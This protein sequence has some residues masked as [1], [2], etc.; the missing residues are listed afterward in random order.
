MRPVPQSKHVLAGTIFLV[1]ATVSSYLAFEDTR[2]SDEQIYFATA[3]AKRHDPDLY[4]V[5][6]VYGDVHGVVNGRGQLW[7]VQTP[8]FLGMMDMVLVPEGYRHL[9]LPFRLM[10]GVVV[11]VFLVG[12][13]ALLWRQ[14]RSSSIA[15][16]GAVLAATITETFG[17]WFWG[18]GAL[19]SITPQGLVIALSPLLLLSYVRNAERGRVALT[20]GA[21]GLCANLHLISAANLALILF[22]VYL[23]QRRFSLRSLGKSLLG[24]G[25]FAIGAFPYLAYFFALR[26]SLAADA[27]ATA[28]TSSVAVI[29]ALRISDMAVLYPELLGPLLQWGIYAVILAVPPALVLWR[30]ERFRTRDAGVWLW[31]VAVSLL[32]GLVL[33]GVSQALGSL[34]GSAPPIIDFIQAVSWSMLALYVLFA[35]AI[36]HLFRIAHKRHRHA[37]RW[38]MAAFLAAWMLP[39]DNLRVVRHAAYHLPGLVAG[40]EQPLRVQE[41]QEER[42]EQ[43]ELAAVG[44]W[45][46][47]NTD[48]SALFITWEDRFRVEARRSLLVC[49]NDV[50]YYYY[51]APWLLADW[52]RQ[53]EQQAGWLS[54]PVDTGG[55]AASID[56]LAAYGVL[57]GMLPPERNPYEPVSEWY[58]LL[59]AS[60]VPEQTE[61]LDEVL[62]DA[63]PREHWRLFRVVP[64]TPTDKHALAWK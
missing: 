43:A 61:R 10:A 38:A 11:L 52:T 5:D 16:F 46:R 48:I 4:P 45:A 9:L 64:Q 21:I 37:L 42:A 47:Q 22:G 20:F 63:W 2:F 60:A 14:T 25:C 44:A 12:M 58:V 50:R 1:V 6:S 3:A 31:M 59:A 13:Y 55:L 26:Y 8:V 53:I 24:L 40:V 19:A 28:A 35:Q 18:V 54:P 57:P 29:R 17:N 41:L 15:T 33:H 36:T 32:V 30:V 39:S 7:R 34:W 49:R 27:P 56:H 51:L 62:S 23:G